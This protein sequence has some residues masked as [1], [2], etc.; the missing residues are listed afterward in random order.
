LPYIAPIVW[1]SDGVCGY[2]KPKTNSLYSALFSTSDRA[3]RQG[4]N[5]LLFVFVNLNLKLKKPEQ[6]QAFL[7]QKENG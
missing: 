3:G 6:Q 4:I 2:G 1:A 7:H 5:A